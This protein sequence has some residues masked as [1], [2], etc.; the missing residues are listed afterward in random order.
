[1]LCG[2]DI[3]GSAGNVRGPLLGRLRQMAVNMLD[4][5]CERAL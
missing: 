5:L 4:E 3:A 2:K 1:M